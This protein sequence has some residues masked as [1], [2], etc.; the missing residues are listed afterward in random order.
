MMTSLGLIAEDRTDVETLK[1]LIRRTWEMQRVE[2]VRITARASKGCSK[3]VRKASKWMRELASSGCERVILVH[4][5][6]RHDELQLRTKLERI[7]VPAGVRRLLCIPVEELE[8][9]FWS[10]PGVLSVVSRGSCGDDCPSPHLIAAPKEEL[11]RL[12][13]NGGRKPLYSTAE[14]PRLAAL[15]DMGLC[16]RRCPA[17]AELQGFVL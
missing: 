9:W 5:R 15:L 17:F 1:V 10:D 6:D 4:D 13:S 16:A 7:E 11:R 8:A 3:L 2:P 14:N 12:S